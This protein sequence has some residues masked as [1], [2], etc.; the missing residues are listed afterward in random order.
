MPGLSQ[1][2]LQLLLLLSIALCYVNKLDAVQGFCPASSSIS[3]SDP[4]SQPLYW[5]VTN[6]TLSPYHLKDLLGFTSSVHRR[7]HALITPESHEEHAGS[8][9]YH[10]GDWVAF[11]DVP[12][13]YAR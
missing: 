9:P 1:S 2:T 4:N 8:I 10:I 7:D 5:K 12:C 11:C 13:Q 3:S 6:P